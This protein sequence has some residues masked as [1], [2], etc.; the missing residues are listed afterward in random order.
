MRIFPG[1]FVQANTRAGPF[2]PPFLR[3]FPDRSRAPF[4]RRHPRPELPIADIIAIHDRQVLGLFLL[5]MNNPM[6]DLGPYWRTPPGAVQKMNP[7]ANAPKSDLLDGVG[8]DRLQLF[9]GGG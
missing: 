3:P 7:M 8:V 2:F 9:D 1:R 4:F 6:R 5:R